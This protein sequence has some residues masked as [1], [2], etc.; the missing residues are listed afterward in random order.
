MSDNEIQVGDIFHWEMSRRQ[1]LAL[2]AATVGALA[3]GT[4][5]FAPRSGATPVRALNAHTPPTKFEREVFTLCEQCVWRCGVRAKVYNGKVYKLDGNPNHPHSNGMLCPRGQAGIAALYDPD[6]LQFPMVRAGDRG[7]GMWKRVTWNEALDYVAGKLQAIKQQFGAEA[8]VFSSTHNLSQIQFENLLRAYGSP[9]Y[10]TQRS[11]CFNAMII[12]N[13]LTFGMQEPNRDYSAAKYIIYAGRNLAEAISNSETQDL[14]AA[15]ARGARVVVLDPRFTKTA[16]KATEWLPIRPGTDLAFFLAM[17]HVLVTEGLYDKEFVAKHTIG[18]DEVTKAVKPYT[19]EWA[20]SK[21]EIPAATIRRI[22]REFALAAPHAFI[23]PNWRTSNFVNSFQAERAMAIINAISGNWNQPGGLFA[24]EDEEGGGLGSI[25][26]PPYPR[27]TALRLD[28]VPWKYPLVPLEIGV[29][30]EIRDAILAGKPYQAKGWF[31]YRQN[32]IAALPER[33]KT[34]QAFSKLDFIVTVDTTMNDTAWFSD[35]VLPEATYLERYDPLAV[36]GDG[37]FIRQPVVPALGESKSALWIFKELGTRLG[38][39]DYF[40]YKDEEDYIRQQLKPLGVSLEELKAKGHYRPPTKPETHAELKF[41][42]PSGKIELYSASLAKSNFPGVPIWQEP[43][44]PPADQFYLLTGKVALHTQ[45]STQN[46]KL[47]HDLFPT[48]TVWIHTK[49]AAE[50]GI[51]DGDWVYV[52]SA[53]GKVKIKATVTEAIRPDCVYMPP[54]FGHLSKGNRVS[55]A[56]GASSSEVHLTYT[57]PV[58]GGQALSQT[59]VKV[60]KA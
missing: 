35:V 50:R 3:L 7:S 54:G 16:S 48:N 26:Q 10:G 12:A 6:R 11:L 40:Q 32:P 4:I 29:Y 56:Q 18:F 46:N 34:L 31:V 53:A 58:S 47:L 19:P 45:F 15:I 13:L 25:P 27:V 28:G 44:A 17:L 33:R 9:N 57:D 59:F 30:Q 24:G 41:N 43:P 42:T 38:L 36:V 55:Y 5:P 14:V 21:C 39:Q 49:P 2:G 20:A 22:A 1:F 51:K 37:V 60:Y 8:M 23:H 52:E